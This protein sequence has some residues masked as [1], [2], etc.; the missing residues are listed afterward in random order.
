[1]KKILGKKVYTTLAE[2]IA[3]EHTA[4]LVVDVQNDF[5]TENG[6]IHRLFGNI[7][8]AVEMIPRLKKLVISA[9]N[10]GARVV[11]IKN[12]CVPDGAYHSPADLARRLDTYGEAEDILITLEGSW[13]E[14]LVDGLQVE[15][16]DL[17]IRKYRPDAFAGTSLAQALRSNA[18]E[19]VI[20]TGT[21]TFACVE[22]TARR[23]LMEDF[24]VTVVEDCVAT[25]DVSIHNASLNIMLNFFGKH[26]VCLSE[27]VITIWEP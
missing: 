16:S 9:R 15:E 8:L 25:P 6:M 27:D 11:F 12:C 7:D 10:A 14:E 4:L 21:A 23:A 2:R 5:C 20:V 19:S 3:P 18:I 17:V 13:G 24:Y 26:G 22:S 1:M